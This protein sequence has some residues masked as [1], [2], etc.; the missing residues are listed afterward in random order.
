MHG[1]GR[2]GVRHLAN[3]PAARRAVGRRKLQGPPHQLLLFL[4]S[5]FSRTLL[6]R[7]AALD[8]KTRRLVCRRVEIRFHLDPRS[9]D[10]KWIFQSHWRRAHGALALACDLNGAL[11]VL[12]S[13]F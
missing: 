11:A 4:F 12:G 9:S 7:I 6:L 8:W 3:T 13:H 1:A 5:F 10:W 2:S